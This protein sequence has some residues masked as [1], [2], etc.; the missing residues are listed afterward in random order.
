MT[1]TAVLS[2]APAINNS[3]LLAAKHRLISPISLPPTISNTNNKKLN[4]IHPIKSS[5]SDSVSLIDGPTQEEED[6]VKVGARVRVTVPLTVYHVPKVPELDLHGKEGT[7][8]EN[9]AVWKGKQISANYPIK[10]E[11]LE[12]LEGRGDKPVKFFAHLK[13][14]EFEYID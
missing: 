1:S 3:P 14:D 5:A 2:T 11:F 8:K 9:V 13:D 10:I 12:V 4:L 7:V 6:S